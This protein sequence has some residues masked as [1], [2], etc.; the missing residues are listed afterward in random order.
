MTD[1]IL[2]NERK[3]E[4]MRAIAERHS[5]RKYKDIPLEEETAAKL[6]AVIDSVNEE[7]GLHIQLVLNEPRAFS[8]I[9]AHYGKFSG[10]TS[11][12]AMA[13][14]KS[15]D[16]QEKIGYYGE[17]IVLEAQLLGLN[18]CWVAATY[19]R[20]PGTITL[21]KGEKLS[22]VIALGYGETQGNTHKSRPLRELCD[23]EGTE[24]SAE[25]KAGLLAAAPSWFKEGLD[26]AQMAPTA[27]NQQKFCFVLNQ[28]GTVKATAPMGFYTKM[29]LGIV[30]YH[31]EVAAGLENFE[32]A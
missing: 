28:N 31:F 16:F 5:V 24:K 17:K 10:V 27:M 21:E 14:N 2:D 32:W 4:L 25:G 11:Y 1:M 7:S 30:K 13:G 6:Q 20:V 15:A 18:T 23:F 8:S 12:I 3:A 22:V 19:R 9:M 29:D 26:A